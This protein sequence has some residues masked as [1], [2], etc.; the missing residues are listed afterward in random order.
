M[1]NGEEVTQPVIIGLLNPAKALTLHSVAQGN[2]RSV[3]A[4]TLQ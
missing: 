2:G 4:I 1:Q 3:E